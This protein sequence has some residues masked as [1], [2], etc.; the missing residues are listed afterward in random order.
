MGRKRKIQQTEE[1]ADSRKGKGKG[2]GKTRDPSP[3]EAPASAAAAAA[4][5]GDK[6]TTTKRRRKSKSPVYES[7]TKKKLQQPRPLQVMEV[8]VVQGQVVLV[9]IFHSCYKSISFIKFFP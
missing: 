3:D 1:A 4:D 2:R 8:K 7:P 5:T 6:T 9:N